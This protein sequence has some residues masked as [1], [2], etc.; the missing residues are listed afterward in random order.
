MTPIDKAFEGVRPRGDCVTR[1]SILCIMG[2]SV[3][4]CSLPAH[5]DQH[6]LLEQ[7]MRYIEHA[8]KL[9][10]ANRILSTC[11]DPRHTG[12][13]SIAGGDVCLLTAGHALGAYLDAHSIHQGL[14]TNEL[15]FVA[16]CKTVGGEE[17]LH[18]HTDAQHVREGGNPKGVDGCLF[19]SML[20]KT[21][22]L[23]KIDKR[24]KDELI[25]GL[26]ALSSNSHVYDGETHPFGFLTVHQL[27]YQSGD[28]VWGIDG[29]VQIDGVTQQ[30]YVDHQ[31]LGEAHLMNFARNLLKT[32]PM[33]ASRMTN[34]QC[35]KMVIS[36]WKYQTDEIIRI[37]KGRHNKNFPH[38]SLTIMPDGT[39]HRLRLVA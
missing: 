8:R 25:G 27:G 3:L 6:L 12:A 21:P 29:T 9:Y 33:L 35:R 14:V 36:F 20:S 37:E 30:M 26:L 32:A 4:A 10:E 18:R 19:C 23:F 13:R 28:P 7:F 22:S 15:I 24:R 11:L 17:L 2:G 1:R 39:P 16:A 38:A 5:A 34:D 31:T